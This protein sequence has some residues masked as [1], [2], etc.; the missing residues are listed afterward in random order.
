MKSP[1]IQNANYIENKSGYSDLQVLSSAAGYYVGTIYTDPEDGFREPGSRDSDYFR[2]YE[3]A[4]KYLKLITTF[5]G[6]GTR[7]RP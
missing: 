4:E 1:M 2:T 6:A 3:Q 7:D 5:N